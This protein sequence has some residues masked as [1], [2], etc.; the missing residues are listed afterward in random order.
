VD[1]FTP[2]RPLLRRALRRGLVVSGLLALP[3]GLVGLLTGLVAAPCS[4]LEAWA[5]RRGERPW[6]LLA[7]WVVALLGCTVA[8]LQPV[9]FGSLLEHGS[10]AKSTYAT[11]T[12][13]HSEILSP[14]AE[15]TI[16]FFLLC[17]ALAFA[18]ASS[19]RIGSDLRVPA[20]LVLATGAL[21]SV[22]GP[23]TFH[24]VFDWA[25]HVLFLAPCLAAGALPACCGLW[26]LYALL[27]RMEGR[28][29]F[30]WSEFQPAI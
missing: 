5:A 30:T 22:V 21:A 24:G 4:L 7:M 25:G 28:P 18:L 8:Y 11:F 13:L 19:L 14:Q 26:I 27:D 29:F 12:A 20:L 2:Q 3:L 9:Y 16:P 1:S 15:P 10:L 23:R 6:G 17:T